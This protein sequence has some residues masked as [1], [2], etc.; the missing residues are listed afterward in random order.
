MEHCRGCGGP[1]PRGG[2]VPVVRERPLR[3]AEWLARLSGRAGPGTSW[4][5]HSRKAA[6]MRHECSLEN[7]RQVTG[8][9]VP[10]VCL[11]PSPPVPGTAASDMNVALMSLLRHQC[12]SHVV[13]RR[14]DL[15]FAGGQDR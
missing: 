14:R 13:C 5:A 11:L 6:P 8:Q 1:G 12:D 9:L 7:E 4:A 10:V 3:R 2:L 15:L